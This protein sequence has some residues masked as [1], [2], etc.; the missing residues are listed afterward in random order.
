VLRTLIGLAFAV[1]LALPAAVALKPFL[2]GSMT[3]DVDVGDGVRI[4]TLSFH[5]ERPSIGAK[6][7]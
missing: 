1:A 5:H 6:Q 7:P 4:P 3:R 2:P